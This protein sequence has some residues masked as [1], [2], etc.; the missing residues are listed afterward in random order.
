MS[1]FL[2]ALGKR[3]YDK[4]WTF[5]VGWLLILG[6]VV[7]LLEM[8]GI[9]ISSNM[10]IQGTKAQQVTDVLQKEI[11]KLSGGQG[12][13]VF[14]VPKG[15]TLQ[16]PTRL[17]AI[18]KSVAKVYKLH[19]VVTPSASASRGSTASAGASSTGAASHTASVGASAG[20]QTPSGIPKL[21]YGPLVVNGKL[22]PGVIISSNGQ[23]ALFQ[24]GFTVSQTSVPQSVKDAVIQNVTAVQ[25]GTGIHVLPGDNLEQT[26]SEGPAE[27][28]GVAVAAVVLL[29]TLGSVIAA[30]L[31]LFLSLFG[32]GV[33]L[34]GTFA[35]SKFFTVID[36]TP[37]LALMIGLAVGIDYS[38]FIVNRQRRL[39][40]ERKLDARE[41]ASRAI[42]T[43]G[44]AVFFSGLTVVIA[45]C[46]MLV[47]GIQFLSVMALVAA[48]TVFINVLLSL[49]L[50]PALLGLVGERICSHKAR[51]K[52]SVV[53][54]GVAHR[55]AQ[56][57]IR[58]RWV[59]IVGVIVILGTAALP[60]TKMNLG[61]PSGATANLN[62][63]SRQSYA[64]TSSAFGQGFNGP[65]VAVVTPKDPAA[66]VSP[67]LVASLVESLQKVRDVSLVAMGGES[68][69]GNMVAL[70]IIPKSGPDAQA[71]KDL[72]TKLRAP[73][74]SVA[75]Q[76]NVSIGVTGYTAINIDMSSKLAQVFPIF[77]GIIV[78]LS[79]IILLAVFR[80][81]LVPVIA[82][83]GFM[84]SILATF[85]MTTAVFQWGWAHA[86]FGF[87][88]GGPILSFL[89]IMVTGILYGL[90]MD[91]QVFLV[92]SMR[93]SHVHG[94]RGNEAIVHGYEQASRVVVA[95][96]IIM[97]AVFSGFI[98]SP[99]MDIKQIG[100]ALAFGVLVDAFIIRSTMVPALMALFGDKAW[101]IP[102]W[103]DRIL[104]NLDVEGDRLNAELESRP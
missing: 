76:H 19:D 98:F 87:D 44:S 50:L 47:I 45:L 63:T 64:A 27:L 8:N 67:Q 100:F 4:P 66:K 11:P 70:T 26:I 86:L 101:W 38:L 24:F 5:I 54:H 82:T 85:G 39:I 2:Y 41:A 23:V 81:I 7:T 25:T 29:I 95:A 20:R 74:F 102:R 91:Y 59:V 14:T 53:R 96:A 58:Q 79:F 93:E 62:T 89:P 12:S 71:T 57:L 43:A 32:V 48:V 15:E 18:A 30:S 36:I 9:H 42:G 46:S 73:K 22:L 72:V 88:T 92:S 34:M 61:F 3:A 75:Q 37:A 10:T 90:A 55:W 69:N 6:F 60:I 16:T 65:L 51:R 104:P 103:L 99:N 21:P 80:S 68:S 94:H 40:L 35:F 33:G 31:P 49:T 28:A 83:G 77:M 13:V 78:M 1:K 56:G 52:A 17:D 84:L 97:T